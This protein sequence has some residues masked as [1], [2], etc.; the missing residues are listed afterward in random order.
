MRESCSCDRDIIWLEFDAGEDSA[1][2]DSGFAGGAGAHERVEDGGS[3]LGDEFDEVAHEG[4]GLYAWMG[5]PAFDYS[6]EADVL[7]FVVAWAVELGALGSVGHAGLGGGD[8][9]TSLVAILLGGFRTVHESSYR[10]PVSVCRRPC[11]VFLIDGACDGI[12]HTA[13]Q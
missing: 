12:P 11:R 4:G 1:F 3:G 9:F 13:K 10:L 2:E 8:G 6:V 5:I 7:A